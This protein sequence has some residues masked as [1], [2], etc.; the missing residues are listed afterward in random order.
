MP[1][2]E[3]SPTAGEL[4]ADANPDVNGGQEPFDEE[5]AND[6]ALI[7]QQNEDA[8][9][10][11]DYRRQYPEP[12]DETVVEEIPDPALMDEAAKESEAD[13]GSTWAKYTGSTIHTRGLTLSDQRRLGVPESGCLDNS[14]E[15]GT[16]PAGYPL[17]GQEKGLWWSSG[18]RYRVDITNA[19]PIL[20]EYLNEDA[21]FEVVTY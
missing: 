10:S 1:T 2:S 18:N 6:A 15:E 4:N 5:A 7:E 20:V 3:T 21:S 8:T 13:A 12:V 9:L 16:F 17:S 14:G 11:D 19:H